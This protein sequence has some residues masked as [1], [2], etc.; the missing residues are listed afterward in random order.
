M[1]SSAVWGLWCSH[2]SPNK[3]KRLKR[4]RDW[5]QSRKHLNERLILKWE[6]DMKDTLKTPCVW[7]LNV[8]FYVMGVSALC[9]QALS[10]IWLFGTP[11]A[12]SRQ[13]PPSVGFSKQD[14]WS[15]LPF[16]PPERLNPHLLCLRHWPA[17]SLPLSCLGSPWVYLL[18][19][20]LLSRFSRVQP[21]ESQGRGSLV[22]CRL[23]NCNKEKYKMF[24]TEWKWKEDLSEFVAC[25]WSCSMQLNTMW[26]LE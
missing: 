22:R 12:I 1:F 10:C 23:R 16:P 21:G 20:L 11:W 7:I 25:N 8:C 6:I 26:N 24:V 19:L 17:D 5:L 3:V 13:V 18:L 4:H 2:W 14:Y 15:G 9:A